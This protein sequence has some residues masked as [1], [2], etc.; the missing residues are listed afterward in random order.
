[1]WAIRNL[2][3]HFQFQAHKIRLETCS[4]TGLYNFEA[5]ASSN[6]TLD[7]LVL[8]GLGHAGPSRLRQAPTVLLVGIRYASSAP[9]VPP[10]PPPRRRVR[11][12][13]PARPV[14]PVRSVVPPPAPQSPAVVSEPDKK[15]GDPV[16]LIGSWPWHVVS[17]EG[18]IKEE[19][20][21]I[22]A[23]PFELGRPKMY[24]WALVVSGLFAAAWVI[25]PPPPRV[26]E[27]ETE[28]C[29]SPLSG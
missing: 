4:R 28:E 13:Q 8:R 26:E 11:P 2:I 19:E 6:N 10:S 7:M 17:N 5:L 15:R 12:A 27:P 1:M 23:R 3:H 21:V 29:V 24:W 18:G 14:Q 20:R 22:F 9:V 16:R 25:A